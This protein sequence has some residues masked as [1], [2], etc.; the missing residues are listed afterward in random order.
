M[1]N[2]TAITGIMPMCG[3][4]TFIGTARVDAPFIAC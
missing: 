2:L 4:S 3:H 1:I